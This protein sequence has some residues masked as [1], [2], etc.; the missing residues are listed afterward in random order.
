MPERQRNVRCRFL[1]AAV[2]YHAAMES[3]VSL[4]HWKSWLAPLAIV[5]VVL[6][7]QLKT[8][9]AYGATWDE[10]LN[11]NWAKQFLLYWQTHNDQ[12]L[13]D[14]P[15]K[16]MYYGPMFS[17]LTY[18]VAQ[19]SSHTLGVPFTPANHLMDI[20]VSSFGA[21]IFFLFARSTLGKRTAWLATLFLAGYP[22]LIAHAQYNPKDIPVLVLSL[23]VF[24]ALHRTLRTHSRAWAALT[25]LLFGMTLAAKLSAVAL[26][27]VLAVIVLVSFIRS[28][29]AAPRRWI[30][31]LGRD[32]VMAVLFLLAMVAG[33]YV[34]WPT[35]WIKPLLLIDALRVFLFESFWP[36]TV[37]Y[38]GA[39]YA[40]GALPWHYI[41]MMFFI[42]TPLLT[43]A[44]FA[45]GSAVAM[46]RAIRSEHWH[47]YLIVLAWFF[48]PLL[49]TLKPGLV[50]YDGIRQLLFCV[51]AL[52]LLAGI[53]F[54]RLVTFAS[55]KVSWK[56][57]PVLLAVL[58]FGWIAAEIVQVFPFEGSYVNES[59]RAA[60]PHNI[61]DTFEIESWGSSYRQAHDWIAAHVQPG[62]IVCVPIADFLVTWYVWP[63]GIRFGC[64]PDAR[65]VMFFTRYSKSYRTRF[66][67]L[68]PVF[69]IERYNSPL[70]L[71]YDVKP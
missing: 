44:C 10:P 19:F 40:G 5:V 47:I 57:L 65:Y 22:Q 35:L 55:S 14:M 37:L 46:R 21:G 36:G 64:T 51:P 67:Q 30:H 69:S 4:A 29:R 7:L 17:V 71:I 1:H 20:I 25:G 23:F 45:A 50:R 9:D 68:R 61:D 60:I 28:V 62:E 2:V 24:A 39:E 15:G 54:D 66:E 3:R 56:P 43:L 12:Y 53:G 63:D 11:R 32:S 27:P 59:V 41:P 26:L 8:M 16:G 70:L 42:A 38:F 33:I 58:V 18:G 52:A 31:V 13:T 49:L 6:G 48:V 34:A